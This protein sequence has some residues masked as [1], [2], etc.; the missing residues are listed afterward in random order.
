M[1]SSKDTYCQPKKTEP[2]AEY[3]DK[4]DILSHILGNRH[5]Y[6]MS[7]KQATKDFFDD[8]E[9]RTVCEGDECCGPNQKYSKAKNKCISSEEAID[10]LTNSGSGKSKERKSTVEA[11]TENDN[12]ASF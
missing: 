6:K 11:F 5:E 9:G 2:L 4:Q 3:F 10:K 1:P 12:Y 7:G 8:L